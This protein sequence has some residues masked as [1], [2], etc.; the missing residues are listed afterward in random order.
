MLAN[1]LIRL[2]AGYTF[3]SCGAQHRQGPTYSQCETFYLNS[4]TRAAVFENL[5]L[6]G[7]QM[8][9]VPVSS[10]YTYIIVLFTLKCLI[11]FL[12][13]YSP[14]ELMVEGDYTNME[15]ALEPWLGQCSS[16]KRATP[17]L[18]QLDRPEVM[19]VPPPPK[20]IYYFFFIFVNI[21]PLIL[22]FIISVLQGF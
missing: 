10:Y 21:I 15:V 11:G 19:P 4:T 16:F 20:Y 1:H 18:F 9:T 2:H 17:S 13:E 6:N 7:T 12:L 22:I 8:W 5:E 3:T 14:R